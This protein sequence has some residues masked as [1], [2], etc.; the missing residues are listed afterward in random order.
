MALAA[1][2]A[3]MLWLADIPR[4]VLARLLLALL[5]FVRHQANIRRAAAG[6]EPSLRAKREIADPQQGRPTL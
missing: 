4:A 3:L 6:E 1:A 5:G 2:P